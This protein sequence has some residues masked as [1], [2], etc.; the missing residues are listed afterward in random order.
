MGEDLS[1]PPRPP[2]EESTIAH[3]M[4]PLFKDE[5]LEV[6]KASYFCLFS[7]WLEDE[8]AQQVVFAL[9]EVPDETDKDA[10][11]LYVRLLRWMKQRK[12]P[13]DRQLNEE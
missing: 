1:P 12:P 9:E 4:I 13:R 3:L 5:N 8:D 2:D 7:Y 11:D 6:R 10:R